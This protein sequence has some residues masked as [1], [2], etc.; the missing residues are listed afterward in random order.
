[1]LRDMGATEPPLLEQASDGTLML[2]RLGELITEHYE[3]FAVFTTP[4]EFR[5]VADGRT[6]GTVSLQ[7]AFG[8]G[9]YIIFSGL[10]WMVI[11]VDDRGRT[12]R[13]ES[14]PAGRVPRFDGGE[15]GPIHDHL[16]AK[17]RNILSERTVPIYLDPKAQSHLNE[18][19]E[20]FYQAGLTASSLAVDDDQIVLFPWRGTPTLD[21][22]RF[23]L[24]R[25]GLSVTP[26]SI[27]LGTPFK[28]REQLS[29]ALKKL[30]DASVVDGTEL[31]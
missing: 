23:A 29:A 5:I 7:N 17:M 28:D 18:A 30:R 26:L 3:F 22:L 16:V 9:D 1:L 31:A 24:R 8:P 4:E 27:A 12:V 2:G 25:E 13:V 15:P 20:A 14:A 6:L 19:R 11:D 21:A 10:R